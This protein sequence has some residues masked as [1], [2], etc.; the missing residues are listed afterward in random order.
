M[1]DLPESIS[2]DLLRRT[3]GVVACPEQ[4]LWGVVP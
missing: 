2:C 4:A 1:M 3:A